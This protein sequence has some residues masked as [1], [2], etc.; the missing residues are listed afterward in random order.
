M[1]ATRRNQQQ[2]GEQQSPTAACSMCQSR[3]CCRRPGDLSQSRRAQPASQPSRSA[4]RRTGRRTG[5]RRRCP[6]KRH[7]AGCT[8]V[9]DVP[10]E[11]KWWGGVSLNSRHDQEQA[12]TCAP[13]RCRHAYT[14]THT[15]T[16][17][18]VGTLC[19]VPF[20]LLR[21]QSMWTCQTKLPVKTLCARRHA[22]SP[23][24]QTSTFELL[25]LISGVFFI[26][27]CTGE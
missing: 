6:R 27:L 23:L 24:H 7:G 3:S 1:P 9:L 20:C 18:R 5:T 13:K 2:R 12:K 17:T 22:I 16:H 11:K 14:H 19:I 15:H 26:R 21:P 25:L 10:R 4:H 8:R